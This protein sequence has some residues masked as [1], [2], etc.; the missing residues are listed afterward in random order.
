[1]LPD[2]TLVMKTAITADQDAMMLALAPDVS[3]IAKVHDKACGMVETVSL[4]GYIF[5]QAS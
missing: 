4:R 1:M 5:G 3:T 2:H